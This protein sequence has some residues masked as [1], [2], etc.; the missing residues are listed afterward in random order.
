MGNHPFNV[1]VILFWLATMGWLLVA[2][3]L[4]PLR[5]GEP[6]NYA[7]ILKQSGDE[8]PACWT[9]RMRGNTIGWAANKIVRRD[10]GIS[11]LSS[12]VY[13]GELPLDELAPSWLVKVLKPVF[14]D[15]KRMDLDKRS[16]LAVDPLGRLVEFESRVRLADDADAIKV[17][18]KIEGSTIHL[19]VQSGEITATLS[20]SL[21]PNALVSDELSPQ[22]RMP[23]LRVGQTWTVPLYSPFRAAASPL[24]ILQAVVEREDRVHWDG[25]TVNAR[26]IVY[27]GDSGSGLAGGETRGKM[28]VREDGVVLR[29]EV[30][31]FKSPLQFQR[32]PDSEAKPIW[33]ILGDDWTK[34]IDR[35]LA[36][37][38]LER[39]QGGTVKPDDSVEPEDAA[40]RHDA[41]VLPQLV[42]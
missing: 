14:S 6:P 20:R 34:A 2:K 12:R 24:E 30:A 37:R 10:D 39:L 23:G 26:V 27:R 33:A 7:S 5:V 4:P 31:V 3:I 8:P 42:P 29:Q 35:D 13:L 17:Q 28:W 1:I 36:R 19:T 9:I 25:R 40:E 16:R 38:L 21:S 22:V 41:A 32:L 15:I 11:E 18:G